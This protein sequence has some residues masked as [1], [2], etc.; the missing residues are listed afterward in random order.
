MSFLLWM[1]EL[2]AAR[3]CTLSHRAGLQGGVI[4]PGLRVEWS[5][6]TCQYAAGLSSFPHG[7]CGCRE[8]IGRTNPRRMTC[9]ATQS[10][11]VAQI[12]FT[13][14]LEENGSRKIPCKVSVYTV[15]RIPREA[16]ASSEICGLSHTPPPPSP[17][18]P[19][20]HTYYILPGVAFNLVHIWVL[21]GACSGR[22]QVLDPDSP[23][24]RRLSGVGT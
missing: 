14:V 18:S 8:P 7:S 19:P 20:L 1:Q 5:C 2:Q 16:L 6:S 23:V 12:D 17:S 15:D 3:K 24:Y 21:T 9:M 11:I 13:T 22:I 4:Y 10:I